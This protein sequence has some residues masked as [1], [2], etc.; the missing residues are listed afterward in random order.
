MVGVGD[1]DGRLFAVAADGDADV[2]TIGRELER[3]VEERPQDLGQ[4]LLVGDDHE[5]LVRNVE[6]DVEAVLHGPRVELGDDRMRQ[7]AQI[8]RLEADAHC[9]RIDL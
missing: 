3:V 4:A 1:G 6:R 5:V 9:A 7:G 2:A 8:D